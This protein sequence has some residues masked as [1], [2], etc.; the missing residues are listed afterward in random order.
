MKKIFALILS[1]LFAASAVAQEADTTAIMPEAVSATVAT[2][3]P[4]EGLSVQDIDKLAQDGKYAE[5]ID[6][7]EAILAAGQ[8]SA[9]V[10]YNLGFSYFKSG[11]LGKAIL[12]FERAKRLDPS[13]ADVQANLELAYALTDKMETV[14]MPIVDR[15][16]LS[17]TESFSSDGWA[18]LFILFFFLALAGVAAFLFLDSVAHRKIGFFSAIALFVLAIVSVSVS[19]SKRSEAL[20]SS[21]AII[22]APTADL[23]TSPDKNGVRMTVLHEGTDVK[24]LDELGGWFEVRLR[25]GNVGWIKSAEVEK[26]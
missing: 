22:M 21:R 5:A 15:M 9:G 3:A 17:V 26:I 12:N 14:E 24:I 2:A 8:E 10:Y 16:W 18:W 4:Q 6:A 1:T 13:D 7:Y 19:L 20:D 25:D 11:S 23:T